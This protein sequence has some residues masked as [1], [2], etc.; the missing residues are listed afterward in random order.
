MKNN[1]YYVTYKNK[2]NIRKMDILVLLKLYWN[3]VKFFEIRRVG[4]RCYVLRKAAEF[5]Q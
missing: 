5:I 2:E 1:T 3:F 4:L